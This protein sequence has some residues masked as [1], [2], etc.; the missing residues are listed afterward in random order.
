MNIK[1][2]TL[3]ILLF[4]VSLVYSQQ[5]PVSHVAIDTNSS[6]AVK[7]TIILPELSKTKIIIHY[8]LSLINHY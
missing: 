7:K 2:Y 6:V 8:L 4:A 1:T 5:T 3:S